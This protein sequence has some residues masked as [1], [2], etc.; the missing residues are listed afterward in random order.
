MKIAV[1]TTCLSIAVS[2]LLGC[3]HSSKTASTEKSSHGSAKTNSVATGESTLIR[4]V[5]IKSAGDSSY[6]LP[7]YEEKLLEN[8]LRILFV[9][10]QTLPYVSYS[11][12]VRVGAIQD[13]DGLS[14]VTSLVTELLNKGTKKRSAPQIAADLGQLGADL[15]ASTSTEFSVV[16]ASGLSTQADALL[17]NLLEIVTEPTFSD[18]EIERVR[19]QTLSVI[20]RQEDNPE[21]FSEQAFDHFL[22]GQHP[23]SRPIIGTIKTVSAIRK[24]HIIQQYLHYFRPNNSYL[25]VVGK[26]TPELAGKIEKEFSKWQPREVA[27]AKLPAEEV[28]SGL[29]VEL[30]DKSGLVQAQIHIGNLGIARKDPDFLAL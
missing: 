20:Q 2:G 23:Y 4:H 21:G 9:P 22:F 26:Y 27:P 10:D 7:P 6:T 5:S 14:G 16:S 12:L 11:L 30:I 24:K 3:S 8:G 18:A 1:H 17:A 25:A 28:I 29:K 13:P 15:D 19:K